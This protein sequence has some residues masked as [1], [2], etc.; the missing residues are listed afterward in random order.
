VIAVDLHAEAIQDSSTIPV[1]ALTATKIL[2]AGSESARQQRV[3]SRRDTGGALRART[4]AHP[5]R[6][7]AIIDKP[8]SRDDAGEEVVMWSVTWPACVVHRSTT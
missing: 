1:D 3:V 4:L 5:R 6:S 8:P 2:A 7:I